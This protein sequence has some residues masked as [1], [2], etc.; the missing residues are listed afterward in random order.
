MK[1]NI[2]A[3]SL[4][5]VLFGFAG[6][7][8]TPAGTFKSPEAAVKQLIDAGENKTAAEELLGPGGWELLRSGDDVADR[9][10]FN[11]VRALAVERI[12]FEDVNENCKIA[13]LGKDHWEL[14]LPLVRDGKQWRFDVEAG[15]EE[16]LNRRVGRNE[17]ST[18]AS[19]RAL[20]QAQIEYASVEHDGKPRMFATRLLSNM[21]VHDGLYWPA[22]V[23]EP[24]S[25][26]GEFVAQAASEGYPNSG[27]K[28]VPYHGY[29][30]RLLTSQGASA[31]GGVRTYLDER[32]RLT[33]GFAILAWPATYGNSG[34]MSFVINQ[35]GIVF[36]KDL[37]KD[38]ANAAQAIKSYDPD[39]TWTPTAD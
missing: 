20:A 31:P 22:A 6:C 8:S 4:A 29:L 33:R 26:L 25:P 18:T 17:I 39:S 32:E 35:Q 10:D 28:P 13:R 7:S 16:V 37:G 30:F 5:A 12:E 9:E 27:S 2:E 38:T 3:L 19:L 34:V 14:P 21:G 15:R 23:G 24:E 11:A 1:K 36:E